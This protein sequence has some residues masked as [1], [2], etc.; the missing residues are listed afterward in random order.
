MT[1]TTD[2]YVKIL[3]NLCQHLWSKYPAACSFILHH[4]NAF[5]HTAKTTLEYLAGK[6]VKV[7]PH[8]PCS[9][10]LAPCDFWLFLKLKEQLRNQMFSTNEDIPL[11]SDQIFARILASKFL[12]IFQKLMERWKWCVKVDGH[13]FEIRS[14]VKNNTCIFAL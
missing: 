8:L 7:L 1:I 6:K 14:F 2:A 13:H 4:N 12:K 5:P 9:L 3:E 11:G 10:D